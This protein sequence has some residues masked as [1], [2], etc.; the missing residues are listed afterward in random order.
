MAIPIIH[1]HCDITINTFYFGNLLAKICELKP[2][3]LDVLEAEED[4]AEGE[5]LTTL[6]LLQI[7]YRDASSM[8]GS[9]GQFCFPKSAIRPP[10]FD[11]QDSW[12]Y[13]LLYNNLDV[14]SSLYMST[15]RFENISEILRSCESNS[16]VANSLYE[17]L[18][19]PLEAFNACEVKSQVAYTLQ[20]SVLNKTSSNELLTFIDVTLENEKNIPLLK[21]HLFFGALHLE[22][23]YLKARQPVPNA[24]SSIKRHLLFNYSFAELCSAQKQVVKRF[25][26]PSLVSHLETIGD[27]GPFKEVLKEITN[28]LSELDLED[29]FFIKT[30]SSV[31]LKTEKIGSHEKE[32]ALSVLMSTLE[33]LIEVYAECEN[34]LNEIKSALI[35]DRL[36]LKSDNLLT[37][38]SIQ[39]NTLNL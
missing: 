27:K 30:L 12:N 28:D 22:D 16:P 19:K 32:T 3:Y 31:L 24:L 35:A 4:D 11:A 6:N 8:D 23:L 37:P 13:Y 18:S 33:D 39:L 7:P 38:T 26:S 25:V 10:L 21:S 15:A 34:D 2:E 20:S 14:S 5:L 9:E 29:G 17:L 1:K 36:K